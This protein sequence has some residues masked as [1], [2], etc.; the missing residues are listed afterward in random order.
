L[1]QL[2]ETIISSTLFVASVAAKQASSITCAAT[3]VTIVHSTTISVTLTDASTG[4]G[5]ETTFHL[6]YSIDDGVTWEELGMGIMGM[7]SL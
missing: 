1:T 5:I 2:L 6:Y 7:G 4:K 3:P